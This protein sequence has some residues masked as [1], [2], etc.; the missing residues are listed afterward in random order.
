M[1]MYSLLLLLFL[2]FEIKCSMKDDF[3]TRKCSEYESSNPAFSLD[4][5][6]TT[7]YDSDK[8]CCYFQYEDANEVT[9]Y[10]CRELSLSQYADID[11]YIDQLEENPNNGIEDVEKLD[12]HSSYLYASLFLIFALIF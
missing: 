3:P 4:F 8:K 7:L 1:K 9:H 5:C 6:R 12:C 11:D 10:H 2:T